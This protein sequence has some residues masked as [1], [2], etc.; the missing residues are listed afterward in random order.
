M[1]PST[2]LQAFRKA[3]L[4]ALALMLGFSL[5][6][7]LPHHALAQYQTDERYYDDDRGYDDGDSRS[8]YANYDEDEED[9]DDV[10]FFHD[11]LIEHGRWIT[12]RDYGYV[13]TPGRVDG[14][15]RPYTR[16]YWANTDDY[17]WYWVSDEPWGWATYHYGRWFHDDR[18]GWLWVPGTTWGPSWVTWRYSDDYVGWA[19]LPPD[20]FWDRRTGLSFNAALYDEPRFSFYW[21]FVEPRYISTPQIYRYVAPR[22]RTRTIVYRTRPVTSYR[23]RGDNVFNVGISAD[24]FTRHLGSP[25]RSVRVYASEGRHARGFDRRA[26]DTIRVWRPNISRHWEARRHNQRRWDKGTWRN[27]DRHAY[28][29]PAATPSPNR[30]RNFDPSRRP[31]QGEWG[32][33]ADRGLAPRYDG[34]RPPNGTWGDRDRDR[35]RGRDRDRSAREFQERTPPPDRNEHPDRQRPPREVRDEQRATGPAATRPA[36]EARPPIAPFGN[37]PQDMHR[38]YGSS[39]PGV[40]RP[41]MQ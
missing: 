13:W 15:W 22:E 11:E 28:R 20:A 14:D 34:I 27:V 32:P 8:G 35:E 41:P 26:G 24:F 2:L 9:V 5:T 33:P 12:H 18:H 21:S 40:G 36:V 23:S 7:A 6:P 1:R 39:I 29:T 38:P 25:L 37:R 30:E 31:S 19:P 10:S 17:G 3:P 16:G 4:T